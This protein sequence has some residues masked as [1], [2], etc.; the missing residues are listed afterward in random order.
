MQQQENV[1][2][3]EKLFALDFVSLQL[4]SPIMT[5]TDR[6]GHLEMVTSDLELFHM[7]GKM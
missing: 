5:P 2:F 7:M 3:L 4:F 1:Q 6:S